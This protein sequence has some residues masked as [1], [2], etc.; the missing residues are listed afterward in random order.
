MTILFLRLAKSRTTTVPR[1]TVTLVLP[2]RSSVSHFVPLTVA[3]PCLPFVRKRPLP[4]PHSRRTF[5]FFADVARLLLL[6][7]RAAQLAGQRQLR[8]RLGAARLGDDEGALVEVAGLGL[9][10]SGRRGDVHAALGRVDRA[11]ERDRLVVAQPAG[12]SRSCP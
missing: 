6:L 9:A 5:F 3:A 12:T 4:S 2:Q 1:L 7:L 11:A 10:A 8:D